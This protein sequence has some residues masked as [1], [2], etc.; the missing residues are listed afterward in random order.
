MTRTSTG[1]I[2]GRNK[3]AKVIALYKFTRPYP[4]RLIVASFYDKKKHLLRTLKYSSHERAIPRLMF[5]AMKMEPGSVI[6][7]THEV[8]G[9]WIG[10]IKI[11][12]NNRIETHFTWDKEGCEH[13]S[14]KKKVQAPV[15]VKKT[16]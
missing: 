1:K 13:P 11:H 7:I 5:Y 15:A 6:Q 16:A 9:M 14:K 4:D 10:D 8:T 3:V 12:V 2:D